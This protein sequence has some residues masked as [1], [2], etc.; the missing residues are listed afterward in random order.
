MRPFISKACARTASTPPFPHPIETCLRV[1]EPGEKLAGCHRV[2]LIRENL[3][4]TLLDT[5]TYRCFDSR[6]EGACAHDLGGELSPGDSVA[7]NRHGSK[8]EFVE[9]E[10]RE[11]DDDDRGYDAAGRTFICE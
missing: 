7:R 10:R 2:S 6:F 8:F 5:C 1:I 11:E 9:R 4:E 3:D